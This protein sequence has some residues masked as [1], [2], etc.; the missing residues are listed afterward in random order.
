[1]RRLIAVASFF[2]LSPLAVGDYNEGVQVQ[3][4][5]K[6]GVTSI[7]Q[8]IAYPAFP[9]SEVTI[10]RV[11]I[12]PGKETGWH[13]HS[14]PVFAHVVQGTLVVEVEGGER[15]QYRQGSALAEVID[16]YHNGRNEGTDEVI[17]TAFFMGGKGIPLSTRKEAR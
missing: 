17:L 16:T 8:K 15:L 2:L 11:T 6:T 1:M 4:L 14:F 5:L 3:P 12:P 13:R 9:D 7:G 10:A